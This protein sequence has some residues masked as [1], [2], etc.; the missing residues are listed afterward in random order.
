[1]AE[2]VSK[3]YALA[4]FDAGL[5]LDKID[6]FKN[7]LDFLR[8]VF[9]D[10]KQLMD[11]LS[12]PRIKRDDK[13]ELINKIF[14]NKLSLELINFLYILIDKRRESNIL[15]IIKRYNIFFNEYKDIVNVVAMTAVPMEENS[16]NN[17][18]EVLSKKLNKTIK[19]SN[20]IDKSVIGGVLLKI[21]DKV[22]DGTLKGQLDSIS[23]VIIGTT[24]S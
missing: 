6:D 20:E 2:L 22:I 10:E 7:E 9:H 3:R 12:H 4:L 8:A 18:V 23:K 13:K 24:T 16:K 19:L 5:E 1:M 15:D 17:L 11:L 14:K 21:E